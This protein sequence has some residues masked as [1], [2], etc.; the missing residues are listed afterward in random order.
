MPSLLDLIDERG[1][2]AYEQL[3]D[4][5]SKMSIPEFAEQANF[6]FLVGKELYDGTL[7]AHS[8][9]KPAS[10]TVRF[11]AI[12]PRAHDASLAESQQTDTV[13]I[14]KM[15]VNQT[16]SGISHAIYAVR[17]KAY[18]VTA[19]GMISIG[20]SSTNDIVIPDFVISKAHASI[21]PFKDKYFISDLSSTNGT[22]VDHVR[23]DPG[24]KVQIQFNSTIA[25]G[26]IVF[27]FTSAYVIY[28][29]LRNEALG[30]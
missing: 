17:R 2:V 26:R 16:D 6:P 4:L 12:D 20:R 13:A 29:G 8:S 15:P 7:M 9:N 1:R 30:I 19:P 22:K 25:L 24:A 27:I 21:V 14:G 28:K 5:V 23:I 11:R 10:S 18:S 3:K